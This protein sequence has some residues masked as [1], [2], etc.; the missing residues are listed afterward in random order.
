MTNAVFLR[1]LLYLNCVLIDF[2]AFIVIFAVSR[3]LA[4]QKVP[5]W[6]L[7]VA[8]AGFS[9]S[10][11]IASIGGGW[12]AHRFDS[13]AVYL[14][15]AVLMVAGIG[16]CWGARTEWPS[17]LLPVY[18]LLGIALGLFYPPLMGWLNQGEDVHANRRGVSRTLILF[19][20]AWN[21]G[22]MC[23]QL[24][25]GSLFEH[26]PLW[27]FGV[28]L[29]IGALNLA[30]SARTVFHVKQSGE[31]PE[32]RTPVDPA[33]AA[34]ANSF[35]RLGWIAN[36]GGMFG[37]AM[38][39]H[40]LP[41]LAVLIGVAPDDHGRMLGAWRMLIIATYLLLH[42]SHFWHFRFSV[43]V[44]SQLITALGLLV[45]ASAHSGNTL[46]F[47]LFLI[48]QL[49]GYNYFSGL[50][51]STVGSSDEN[52]A[53]AAGVHEATLA[54]GMAVGTIVGGWLGSAINQRA[55]YVFA[56]AVLLTLVVVQIVAWAR[57]VRP[58]K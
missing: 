2:A 8:G 9:L 31:I 3:G 45:I 25:A 40:L 32:S 34:L 13:R 1:R 7:G 56:A 48:G 37:G 36:L 50:Y 26:G 58:V 43:S 57:W 10:A 49:V 18:W 46:L 54:T 47:G 42:I 52:R 51:Y 12:I 24:S 29:V 35:K 38:I 17:L 11:A 6:Y 14:T 30:V 39:V 27:T 33:Q 41:G 16:G 4:E 28:A 23:G 53:L 20:V 5:Q 44:V 55:P 22:M 19:C 15:G 21:F